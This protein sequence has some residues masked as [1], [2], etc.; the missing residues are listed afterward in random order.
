MTLL[1]SV[2]EDNTSIIA[3]NKFIQDR[4]S[5]KALRLEGSQSKICEVAGIN[6]PHM[7]ERLD[8]LIAVMAKIELPGPGR[9]VVQSGSDSI[10]QAPIG[11]Q[12][13]EKVFRYRMAHPS[14][15]VEHTSG[16]STYSDGFIRFILDLHDTCE[17]SVEWFCIQ[18]E[19]PCQTVRSWIRADQVKPYQGHQPRQHSPLSGRESDDVIDIIKDYSMWEGSLRDFI[20]YEAEHLCLRKSPIYR[21]LKIYGLLRVRSHKKPRYRGS[22]EK[23]EPGD[24][25][26]TD[27]KMVTVVDTHTGEVR[28]FNWQGI[29]DQ[30]TTCH[31]AVVV[32]DTECAQG[33][34]EAFDASCKFI[35]HSPKALVHDNKPI[36]EEV[37]LRK[38]IEETTIMI[39][40]TPNRGENKA[41]IEGEFGKFEQTVGKLYLDGSSVEQ[42]M[43][44]AASE[45][46]RAYTSGIN[47]AGRDEFDGESREAVLRKTCPDP[48]K[49]RK[50]IED[51]HAD[52]TKKQRFEPLPTKAT[53]RAILDEAFERF[54]ITDLDPKGKIRDWIAGKYTPEA[55]RK[56]LAIFGTEREKGRLRNKTAHRYLVTLI[57]SCQDDLDLRRQEELLREFAE[58]ERKAWLRTLEAEYAQLVTDTECVKTTPDKD[59]VFQLAEKAIFGCMN[60]QRAFWEDKLEGHLDEQRDRIKA[61]C[62]HIN[63]LYET[64]WDNRFFLI[65]K[66]VNWEYR[67]AA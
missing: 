34:R 1:E 44:S 64:T 17:G 58:V 13:R 60:L 59:L 66:L 27:G 54:G 16:H 41:G 26:V 46:L 55:I 2:T 51:L 10:A 5:V 62:R 50:F 63:R 42:F 35:G 37:E 8:Q 9:P 23:C 67:L 12:F 53:N 33:V 49:N 47:H 4:A 22:T 19:I 6:R 28:E 39:P 57:Q 20:K 3:M 40:A 32:T 61:V 56:G 7:Y 36:H 18:A 52:H 45:A 31:T 21:V 48:E 25:L 38:H 11:W 65:S 29:I 30:A 24:I 43:K 14:A 15:L